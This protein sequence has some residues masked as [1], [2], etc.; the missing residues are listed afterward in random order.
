MDGG[1]FPLGS[2]ADGIVDDSNLWLEAKKFAAVT[3]LKDAGNDPRL[4]IDLGELVDALC[5]RGRLMSDSYLFGSRPP[6]NDSVWNAARQRKFHVQ[7]FDR[8]GNS[9]DRKEKEVDNAMATRLTAIATDIGV[10]AR[11]NMPGAQEELAQTVF[12]IH[13]ELWA[14][15]AGL[16]KEFLR[17][18]NKNDLLSVRH[19]DS[20]FDEI[21]F[22]NFRSTRKGPKIDA[23]RALV[24]SGFFSDEESISNTN[25]RGDLESFICQKLILLD[26]LFFVRW[27][28]SA[29]ELI[30]EFPKVEKLEDLESIIDKTR[31]LFDEW[32]TVVSVAQYL[33]R[34][35]D[36]KW[37]VGE[38]GNVY[39]TVDNIH[40]KP[41]E[42]TQP[43]EVTSEQA[44]S[45]PAVDNS[46]SPRA[47]KITAEGNND[48][49]RNDDDD[50]GND[51]DNPNPWQM[52][53]IDR[54]PSHNR[55]LR[56]TQNC[57]RGIH[58]KQ[59]VE[60]GFRHTEE[61]KVLFSS[62]R[63]STSGTGSQSRAGTGSCI[64]RISV[65]GLTRR[66]RRGAPD[67]LLRDITRILVP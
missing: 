30:V 38:M 59:A 62:T 26:R 14:W 8:S 44:P 37:G 22:T 21:T 5:G 16:S 3:K 48:R 53:R 27:S 17:L 46:E 54:G 2:D 50:G 18:T 66:R 10:R 15:K 23:A 56:R 39:G 33:N 49:N 29:T 40:Y 11:C 34:S 63:G 45:G 41:D 24:L 28:Q 43:T 52:V 55:D 65:P 57:S 1:P 35:E 32:L 7:V 12:V 42:Q 58:C 51:D 60:C 4:R 20:I 19:L 67:V 47:D 61:E 64:L 36:T 25:L 6:P 31:Q 13:V 9:F